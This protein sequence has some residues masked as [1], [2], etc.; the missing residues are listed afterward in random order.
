MP[1]TQ[2]YAWIYCNNQ[3]SASKI[4]A[5]SLDWKLLASCSFN[6]TQEFS[7]FLSLWF[8]AYVLQQGNRF[9]CSLVILVYNES[10][11]LDRRHSF[12]CNTAGGHWDKLA[13]NL[14]QLCISISWSLCWLPGNF[15]VIKRLKEANHLSFLYFGA[16]GP[17][18]KLNVMT[19]S[20]HS[21]MHRYDLA[22]ACSDNCGIKSRY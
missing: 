14:Q 7:R 3:I 15:M 19:P 5:S 2:N 21:K 17:T 22:S 12:C 4:K 18:S 1:L 13:E 11:F 8:T 6:Q 20:S 9:T 16:C 10:C